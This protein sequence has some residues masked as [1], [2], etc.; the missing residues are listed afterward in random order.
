MN[1]T[2]LYAPVLAKIGAERSKL[3]SEAKLKLLTES[4]SLTE[5]AVQLRDTSYQEQIAKVP[6]PLTSR[7][8]ERAFH[9]NL[10]EAYVKI[11]KN[12]PKT[13]K[14]ISKFVLS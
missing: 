3:L 8:L 12:S 6:L 11:I 14:K 5:L 13:R 4:R 1:Q 2:T 10:I 7:K 9:E